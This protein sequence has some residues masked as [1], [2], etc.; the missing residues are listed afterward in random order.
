MLKPRPGGI[1][2]K[3]KTK[4]ISRKKAA[5]CKKNSLLIFP[6]DKKYS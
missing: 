6:S 1:D 5:L 4:V 2:K 3:K